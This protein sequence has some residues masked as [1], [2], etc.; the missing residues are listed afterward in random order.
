MK[1]NEECR[2]EPV[3]S[4]VL[5]FS[6]DLFH[7]QLRCFLG[8]TG[9]GSVEFVCIG[10]ESTGIAFGRFFTPLQAFCIVT[11]LDL[12][13]EINRSKSPHLGSIWSSRFLREVIESS[14]DARTFIDFLVARQ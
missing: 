8:A 1:L 10:D 7:I 11:V 4:C 6:H 12:T 3:I 5:S 9:L 2:Y 13:S 14:T